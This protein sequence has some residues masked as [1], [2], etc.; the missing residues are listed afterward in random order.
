MFHSTCG[1]VP[2]M[3]KTWLATMCLRC[4]NLNAFVMHMIAHSLK[5]SLHVFAFTTHVRSACPTCV[6]C[7]SLT[8][9]V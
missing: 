7:M 3:D 5:V 2:E 1:V 9:V 4:I 6:Q 8:C